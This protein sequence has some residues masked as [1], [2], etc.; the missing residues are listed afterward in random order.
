MSSLG[1]LVESALSATVGRKLLVADEN[2]L[3]LDFTRL[4]TDTE[5]LS[6]R[7]DIAEL[8]SQAG[9]TSHFSDYDFTRWSDDSL[10]IMVY[11]LS[12]E[13]PVVHHVANCAARKLR[14]GGQLVLLGA[15]QEGIKTF[16][17]SVGALLNANA[18][19]DKHKDLYS[20]ALVKSGSPTFWLD[21]KN[22]P[23]LREVTRLNGRPVLSK[24]GLF[25]WNKID[26]GSAILAE[27]LPLFLKQAGDQSRTVLDL[28]CGYG[29]LSLAAAQYGNFHF[30]ATD[31]CSAAV[32]ACR[33]NFRIH[34]ISGSVIADDCGSHIGS[35]FDTLL[36]NPP[37][38]QGFQSDRQLTEKFLIQARRLL[39]SGG[40]CLFVV[41]Q[42][43]PLERLAADHF[44]H[45][46]TPITNRGFKL[47]TLA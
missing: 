40:K 26:Q 47:V 35:T 34:G 36:C 4:T 28:G 45:I 25:G 16:A 3:G 39:K 31:N 12:K 5:V 32:S 10:D 42:F 24:P 13:K 6:N 38:H 30:T 18:E 46:A 43:V 19:T 11:R 29:Y 41:N 33:E 44:R 22:Y 23:T 2:A 15:K 21:D 8:A 17:K 27:Y 7:F 14:R 9:C 1:V 20:V 37:F